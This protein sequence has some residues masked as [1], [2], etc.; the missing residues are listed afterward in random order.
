MPPRCCG[1]G[2]GQ[3]E[4]SAGQNEDQRSARSRS[5]VRHDE[6]EEVGDL[7]PPVERMD[8]FI[9]RFQRM[10]PPVFNGDES[11][12]DAD[13]WLWN[14]IG[15]FDRVQ[16]DDDLRLSLVTL[17]LRK[18]AERWWRGA[19]ST[20]LETGV[21]ISWDSF[22]QECMRAIKESD[23]ETRPVSPSQLGS[24]RSNPAVTTPMIALDYSG[25]T[26]QSASRNMALNQ[27][28]TQVLPSYAGTTKKSKAQKNEECSPTSSKE[29]KT[30]SA[31]RNKQ[32]TNTQKLHASTPALIQGLKW[33]A[34]ERANLG[35][36]SAT[37]IVKNKG[38]KRRESAVESYG[39]Q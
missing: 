27:D 10:N 9:A 26:T 35:E 37:K 31:Q 8:V 25:T 2:R 22:C 14:I 39:V 29:L 12:E 36:S 11:S 20:L 17:L 28:S 21:G 15:L 16:Y 13:S 23:S 1:S 24:R 3:F 32:F 34:N 7:P 18:A 6:E 30:E 4:E 38:W 19:S 33:V 5:R